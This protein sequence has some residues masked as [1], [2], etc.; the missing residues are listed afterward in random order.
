MLKISTHRDASRTVLEIE[1]RIVGPWAEELRDCWRRAA[2]DGGQVVVVLKQVS[3]VDVNGKK[4]LA[5]MHRHRVE[6]VAEGCMNTAIIEEI[7][8]TEDQ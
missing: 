2:N 1:G 5:E 3:Y 7:K 6:L 4:V 8:K